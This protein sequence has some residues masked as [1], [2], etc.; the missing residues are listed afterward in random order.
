MSAAPRR[1]HA[2]AVSSW[3]HSTASCARSARSATRARSDSSRMTSAGSDGGGPVQLSGRKS[4]KIRSP[5]VMVL[6]VAR[7]A[8]DSRIADAVGIAPRRADIIG[9]RVRKFVDRNVHRT[10][11]ADHDDRAGGGDVGL[12]V[13]GEFQR[14]AARNRRPPKTSP[15]RGPDRRRGRGAGTSDRPGRRRQRDGTRGNAAPSAPMRGP[16]TKF[17]RQ[18]FAPFQERLLASTIPSRAKRPRPRV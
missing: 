6:T 9:H 2:P 10:L 15:R 4:T 14:S 5:A 17:Q 7:R 1:G 3:R 8:S 16:A 13:L 11:E 12:D 18:P